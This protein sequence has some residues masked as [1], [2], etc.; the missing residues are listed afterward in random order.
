MSVKNPYI[1][2]F[3]GAVAVLLAAIG[4]AKGAEPLDQYR[5]ETRPLVIFAPAA[6]DLLLVEQRALLIAEISGLKDRDMNVV[7]VI[8]EERAI[9]EL[10]PQPAATAAAFRARFKVPTDQFMV[11]LVGKD[12]QEKYRAPVTIPGSILFDIIDAMPM[13]QRERQEREG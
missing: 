12:G 7:A 6:D 13:R 3:L 11:I 5:W 2:P 10:G 9:S 4:M 1:R 8:G